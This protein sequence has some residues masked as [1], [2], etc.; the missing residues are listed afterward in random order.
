MEDLNSSECFGFI[1][2]FHPSKKP[3]N[4]KKLYSSLSLF[5]TFSLKSQLVRNLLQFKIIWSGDIG[6]RQNFILVDWNERFWNVKV[7]IVSK[8]RVTN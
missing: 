7:P 2:H 3:D 5:G 1:G 8:N 6:Q 4:N